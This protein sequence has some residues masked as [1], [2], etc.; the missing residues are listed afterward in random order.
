L[1]RLEAALRR[2]CQWSQLKRLKELR[3]KEVSHA[4]LWHLNALEG[5]VMAE[6]DYVVGVQKR[7]GAKIL[8]TD[9]TCRVC[10]KH[11]DACVSHS[12][13]C[14]IGEATRGHYAVVRAVVDGLKVADSA[15][16]TEPRGL[17]ST[18]AR[19][20]DIFTSAAVPGRSAA[21]DVCIASPDAA[22]AGEDAAESAF[23]RKL[24]HYRNI[25]P[26]LQAAGVAFRPLIWTADGRPH[27]AATRTLKY[28]A[29][30]A[31]RKRGGVAVQGLLSRWK[32]EITV[33]I[34]RRRAAML[35]AVLP[36]AQAKDL[37]MLTGASDETGYGAEGRLPEIEE[38]LSAADGA[39]P[40]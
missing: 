20:A 8:T 26:E 23:R 27:P 4:W 39:S 1:R 29:E 37:W 9:C 38:Q 17:T 30:A 6:A 13:T 32:H 15:V 24:V 36:K 2:T 14:A 19:P 5:S 28:A 40:C 10:G 18:Q 7:L 22:G 33:A 35:R 3:H 12:E 21:L 34:I 16:T 25:I 31:A 11:L